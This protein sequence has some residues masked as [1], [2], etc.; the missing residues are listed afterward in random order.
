MPYQQVLDLL[1]I[2]A[3]SQMQTHSAGKYPAV[4]MKVMRERRKDFIQH[5]TLTSALKTEKTDTSWHIG[6]TF[7]MLQS[8]EIP[9][10]TS[11]LG[12]LQ[13]SL[14]L[15]VS[16]FI[17][18]PGFSFSDQHYKIRLQLNVHLKKKF[19]FL[20][21]IILSKCTSHHLQ[22]HLSSSRFYLQFQ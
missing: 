16:S 6:N 10:P 18:W 22:H 3:A 2:P 4:G 15:T 11:A 7:T 9:V 14:F 12:V 8:S 1:N 20:S 21:C 13:E 17:P 5:P 19:R